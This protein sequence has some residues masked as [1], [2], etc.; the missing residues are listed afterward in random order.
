MPVRIQRSRAKGWRMPEGATYVG[1]PTVFGNPFPVDVYGQDGAVDRFRRW[2]V[3]GMSTYEMST[4]SRCDPW[5]GR[6]DP[7]SLV[8]VRRWLLDELP[9]LRGRDL[10]CWCAPAHPCHAD[11][12]LE[13]ANR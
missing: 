8:I 11:V 2:L 10:A 9:K 3:T 5:S 6:S 13:I 1:R 4:C 7:P 12:L